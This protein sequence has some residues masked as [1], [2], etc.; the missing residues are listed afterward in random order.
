MKTILTTRSL[1]TA[2]SWFAA[3]VCLAPAAAMAHPGHH[4]GGGA[5]PSLTAGFLHPL[6][7][8][9][10]MMLALAMGWLVF[11]LGSRH[12]K[13][14]ALSFLAALLAGSLF[15]RWINGGMGL[16][17][18]ISLSILAAGGL[19]LRGP[20]R[21]LGLLSLMGLAGGLVHGLAH[22][23][24]ALPGVS[25]A[26]YACGLLLSTALLLG[27]GA[28]LQRAFSHT[29]RPLLA[30]RVAGIAMIV[31]GVTALTGVF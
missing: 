15:G 6:S 28:G 10:H 26:T 25:F 12:A 20:L 7:G 31:Q 23:A 29:A 9:D 13:V 22:G 4:G 19:M 5:L 1:K 21:K 11:S 3:I 14:P 24:E 17:I 30:I 8:L 18:A 2:T 27:A 16:E